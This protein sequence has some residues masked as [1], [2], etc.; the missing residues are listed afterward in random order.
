MGAKDGKGKRK[1]PEDWKRKDKAT[2][3]GKGKE[4][5]TGNWNGKGKGMVK[6]T[7]GDEARGAVETLQRAWGMEHGGLT[8]AGIFR[9]RSIAHPV[10]MFR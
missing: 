10:N 7:V 1:G 8:R 4:N 6:H 2:E 5:G 3:E 9:A